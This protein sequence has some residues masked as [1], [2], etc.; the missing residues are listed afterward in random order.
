M[1]SLRSP[2]PTTRLRRSPSVPLRFLSLYVV[3]QSEL[4]PYV[5]LSVSLRFLS[6][7]LVCHTAS[8]LAG[9]SSRSGDVA[10]YV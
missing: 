2:V 10:V 3:H 6:L 1:S 5:S 7:R 8:V 4:N 9:S